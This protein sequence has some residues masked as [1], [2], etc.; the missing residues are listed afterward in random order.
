VATAR[1][2]VKR[3]AVLLLG[4]HRDAVS[5]VS[6]HLNLLFSSRLAE[7][8]SLE[9]FQVGSEGRNES[10]VARLVRF[11]TSPLRLAATVLLRRVAIVHLNTA[12]NARAFW[13]DLAYLVAARTCGARVLYQV[14]GGALPQQFF[15]GNRILSAFLR[16]AL[17][18]PDAIVVL[19]STELDAYRKFVPGQPVLVLPNAIDYAPY[20]RL[21]RERP[22]PAGPLRLLYIGR[23][24]RE[25]GLHEAL[26]GLKLARGQ[27]VKAQLVIA[28]SG[29]EEA[30]LRQLVGE[31]GL[32]AEVSFAGPVFGQDKL[33]LLGA[34]DA[35]LLASYA[36]GLPY[37]LLESMAAGVP[38]IA[39]RVGAIPDVATDCVHG[40]FVPPRDAAAVSCAVAALAADRESLARMSAACRRRIAGGYSADRLAEEFGG[41]YAELCAAKRLTMSAR[42]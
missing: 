21:S 42:P 9:H 17:R 2:R 13:R 4:P 34:A 15:G 27:G 25:K 32:T 16:A 1:A 19:A 18:L 5:G 22:D 3:P 23:L 33:R 28:G 29:P 10:A 36:E 38:V 31:L 24:A 11:L 20:A 35:F 30:R 41:L 37:A 40:L 39:T 8:F 6:T 14:H 12:L 7:D 26:R